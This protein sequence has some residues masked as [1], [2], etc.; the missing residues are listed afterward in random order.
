MKLFKQIDIILQSVLIAGSIIYALAA[1]DER[2]IYP[3]F[4]VG[5]WQVTSFLLHAAFSRDYYPLKSRKWYGW[6]L[7]IVIGSGLVLF[8]VLVFYL[9]ALLFVAPVMAIWYLVICFM[10]VNLLHKK[11]FIHLK[12]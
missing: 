10:E 11:A 12:R 8:Y 6:C 1:G 9:M 5:G 4:V 7:V 2:F 3:Y